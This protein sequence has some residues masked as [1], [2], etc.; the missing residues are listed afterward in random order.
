MQAMTAPLA[1]SAALRK[2]LLCSALAGAL[3]LPALAG[4]AGHSIYGDL[5]YSLN[6]IEDEATAPTYDRDTLENNA[7]RIGVKGAYD[8]GNGLSGIYHVELALNPDKGSGGSVGSAQDNTIDRRFAYAGVK[9]GFGTAVFGTASSPYKMAGVKLD[10]FY[11]TSAGTGFGGANFGLSG[12][13]N[14]FFDNVL[15]YFTP[16]WGGFSANAVMVLDEASNDQNHHY[17]LG[18]AFEHAGVGVGLQW[19]AV[20]AATPASEIDAY[21]P[22]VK[23]ANKTF[24]VG[25][26]YEKV[27]KFTTDEKYTYLAGT[28]NATD[29]L[30][31]AAAFGKVEDTGSTSTDGDG[32]TAGVFYKLFDKTELYALYSNVD[33]D[34]GQ[35]R[36]TLALGLSQKFD[37]GIK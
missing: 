37:W 16:N 5:R 24:S 10:P 30:K 27:D 32:V 4:A 28:F 8:F 17:N 18:F 12:F 9:G 33:R 2:T 29:K 3:W 7:S 19:L 36:K 35:E 15:A 31:L 11:D 20:N 13:T 6:S 14:G 1:R 23:Y 21:R 26:S 25:L 22:W 34:S